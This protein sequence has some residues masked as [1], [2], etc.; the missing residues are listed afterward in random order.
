MSLEIV[1]FVVAIPA[2]FSASRLPGKPLRLLGG[3]PLIHRV[4]ERAL[5]AGA[6]E[7]RVATDD[8][9]IAEAVA[10]LDGVHVAIT[11]NTH[12]SGSDR[13]ADAHA[14]PDGILR[15]AWSTHRAMSRSHQRR[16]SVL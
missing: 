10:S 5:S 9:R 1:P 12:L 3:R 4:A 13:L 14:S 16:G 6:R 8:V 11:A 2:R 15:C 7:V